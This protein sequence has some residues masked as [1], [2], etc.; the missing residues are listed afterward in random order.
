LATGAF[1]FPSAFGGEGSFFA[2][3][4]PLADDFEAFKSTTG[5]ISF[6]ADLVI[7]VGLTGDLAG[8]LA[9]VLAFDLG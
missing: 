2:Y 8:V 7:F 3:F 5:L 4:L 9:G 1:L 6:E